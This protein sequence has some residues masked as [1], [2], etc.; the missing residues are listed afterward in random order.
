MTPLLVLTS[1]YPRWQN[2]IEPNFIES[3]CLQLTDEYEVHVLAPH[4]QGAK[5]YEQSRGIHVHRFKYFFGS[6]QRLTYNGGILANLQQ[7]KLNYLLIPLFFLFQSLALYRILRRLEVKVLHAHWVIPQ[8]LIAVLLRLL[9]RKQYKILLTSHGGDLFSL[10]NKYL[11]KCKL[12]VLQAAEHITVVSQVMKQL[13]IGLGVDENKISI[14]PMGVDLQK[15]FIANTA[16]SRRTG[17]I[18]VGRLVEK[19]GVKYLI[20]AVTILR[21]QFPNLSLN[22]VGFGPMLSHLQALARDKNGH[23]I[24]FIGAVKN[25][26]LPT[27]LNKAR[28]AVTPSIIDQVGDQE[29]LGLALIEAMGCGCAVI[30]SDLPAIRDL[31]QPGETGL[32]VTPK[33]TSA[34]AAAITELILDDE[35]AER[36]AKCG[37]EYVRQ[38]FDW[39][40]VGRKY[41]QKIAELS[42]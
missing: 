27:H 36:L 2:D 6:Y 1:T 32:L 41:K 39:Q 18:Y 24:H 15:K 29:G 8:G 3:L 26:D 31:I 11:K 4:Y 20:E 13:C 12:S 7:N 42:R 35:K 37:R 22:I 17:L 38:K 14:A 10:N 19:K 16:Y 40:Q 30:A 23:Y 21:K 34:L 9:C 25:D 28:I 33:S 5:C